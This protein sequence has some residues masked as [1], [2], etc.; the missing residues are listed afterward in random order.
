MDRDRTIEILRK[1]MPTLRERYAVAELGLFGSVARG[2]ADANSDIDVLVRFEPSARVTL[3]TLARVKS[4]IE[5]TLK[6]EIDLVEDHAGLGSRFR[7]TLERDL[8]R[9]A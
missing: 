1:L 6:R 4:D 5:D 3:M 8:I 7:L 2:T 9:V